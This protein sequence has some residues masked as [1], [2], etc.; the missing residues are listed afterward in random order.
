ML[1]RRVL[2]KKMRVFWGVKTRAPVLGTAKQNKNP[3][4]N[5]ANSGGVQRPKACIFIRGNPS[6]E[7]GEE[8]E[9][10][11]GGLKICWLY[12]AV[13]GVVFPMHFIAARQKMNDEEKAWSWGQKMLPG[14][15]RRFIEWEGR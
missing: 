3:L 4:A 5:G 2:F 14:I 9:E 1:W 12:K 6:E 11:E 10:G 15:E 13:G 7:D 8:E